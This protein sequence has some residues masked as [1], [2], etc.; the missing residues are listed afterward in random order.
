MRV[1]LKALAIAS[2]LT[3]GLV[4]SPALYAKERGNSTASMA[5]QMKSQKDMAMKNDSG[6]MGMMMNM[7]KK[8]MK[9]TMKGSANSPS[10]KK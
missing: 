5:S 1:S 10:M 3:L 9:S 4:T 8:M 2:V 7:K 6:C